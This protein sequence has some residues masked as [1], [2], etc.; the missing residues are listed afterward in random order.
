MNF[1]S[2]TYVCVCFSQIQNRIRTCQIRRKKE[3]CVV[4]FCV[5]NGIFHAVLHLWHH[6]LVGEIHWS[7]WWHSPSKVE[8]MYRFSGYLVE[9]GG[10]SSGDIIA[11]RHH[12]FC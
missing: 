1:I 10:A 4:R 5:I 3:K 2:T 12:I 8:Y 7:H 11:V 9:K 6:L